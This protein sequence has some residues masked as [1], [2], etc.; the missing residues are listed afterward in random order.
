MSLPDPSHLHLSEAQPE[1]C[2]L[3]AKVIGGGIQ[4]LDSVHGHWDHMT[5][6]QV[7][8]TDLEQSTGTVVHYDITL[9]CNVDALMKNGGLQ[10][11]DHVHEHSDCMTLGHHGPSRTELESG[12]NELQPDLA[13]WTLTGQYVPKVDIFSEHG[14]VFFIHDE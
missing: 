13:I 1:G 10:K 6:A 9:D 4:I 7:D 5:T 8:L 12:Q 2:Y 11:H 14:Q 3:E